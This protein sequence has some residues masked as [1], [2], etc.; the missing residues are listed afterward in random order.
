MALTY[1]SN[2]IYV[3]CK[4][5]SHQY[6]NKRYNEKKNHS[7]FF[8][9]PRQ[10]ASVT[11]SSLTLISWTAACQA[12]LSITS[13]P[14]LFK[15]MSIKLV[16]PFNQLILCCLLPCL[17][18]LPA[19]GSFPVLHIRCPKY[20]SFSISPSNQYLGLISFRMDWFHLLAVQ[21]TLKSLLQH[22]SSEASILWC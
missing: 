16:M 18:S 20:W 21:G 3:S 12:S 11:Q 8:R 22:D 4:E 10:F 13:S 6:P 7:I 14:S 9:Y 1:N 19:A 17:Q 2:T 15:P 5:I